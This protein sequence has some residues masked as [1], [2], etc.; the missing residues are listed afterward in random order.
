MQMQ[1]TEN[2][3]DYKGY[4]I[5]LNVLQQPTPWAVFDSRYPKTPALY[6]TG[7]RDLALRWVDGYVKG[8]QW[9]VDAKGLTDVVA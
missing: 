8:E 1:E 7:S 5:R 3:V 4:M 2:R 9:A 6:R